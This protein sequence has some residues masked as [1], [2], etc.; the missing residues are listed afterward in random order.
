MDRFSIFFAGDNFARTRKEGAD[1][2]EHVRD[3]RETC[4]AA[5]CNLE[6]V[7]TDRLKAFHRG[8]P[9]PEMAG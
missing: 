1:P 7:L 8:E 9:V 4:Q 2:Y 3:L 6:T 5:F